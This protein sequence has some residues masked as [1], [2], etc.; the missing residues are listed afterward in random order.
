MDVMT[1]L[2][3]GAAT[4]AGLRAVG[5]DRWLGRLRRRRWR[6]VL[7]AVVAAG[8]VVSAAAPLAGGAVRVVLW[9]SVALTL[10]GVLLLALATR[11]VASS[12]D[13][14]VDERERWQ[15]DRTYRIS[16]W[17]VMVPVVLGL[18]ALLG[19]ALD[20]RA[21]VWLSGLDNDTVIAWCAAVILLV[22]AL[23][24]MV[25]AVLEADPPAE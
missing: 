15:R 12:L 16:Y 9:W 20:G 21:V 23:P 14:Y 13:E 18:A 17:L 8:V 25:L 2:R 19:L 1:K 24:S 4:A 11:N 6:V 3:R 10:V 22:G 7:A 5:D